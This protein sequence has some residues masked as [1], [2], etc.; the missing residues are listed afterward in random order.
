M[1]GLDK[2]IQDLPAHAESGACPDSGSTNQALTCLIRGPAIHGR[3][4][5]GLSQRF[6]WRATSGKPGTAR[7]PGE[8][9]FPPV[10]EN[11]SGRVR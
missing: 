10:P 8:G 2:S 6:L 7:F 3:R 4:N 11:G 9:T 5:L 1:G